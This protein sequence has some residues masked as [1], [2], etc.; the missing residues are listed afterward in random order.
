MSQKK[1]SQN[2]TL[3]IKELKDGFAWQ[4]LPVLFLQLS[5]LDVEMPEL[6][7][8]EGGI[9]KAAPFFDSKDLIVNKKRIEIKSRKEKFTSPETF[10]YSTAIVDTV[11]KFEGREEKPFAYI[12]VS[13][14]TGSM[15]WV[16]CQTWKDWSVIEKFDHTR[17]YRDKFYV[18]EREKMRSMDELVKGLKS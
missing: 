10:P 1:W 2:D 9:S 18:I 16:D 4:S 13:R 11:K 6:K 3:F 14:F 17:K 8:R 7:I 12:M 15:L 5:G